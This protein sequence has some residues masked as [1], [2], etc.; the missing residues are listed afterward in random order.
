MTR[1]NS[2]LGALVVLLMLPLAGCKRSPFIYVFAPVDGAVCST[3]ANPRL[4]ALVYFDSAGAAPSLIGDR[5]LEVTM[6][7]NATEPQPLEPDQ[8]GY[9]RGELPSAEGDYHVTLSALGRHGHFTTAFEYAV[10]ADQTGATCVAP[11]PGVALPAAQPE[12]DTGDSG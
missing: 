7:V 9:V 6:T 5:A 3:T 8:L 1:S 2:R 11:D 12:D 10:S 4:E